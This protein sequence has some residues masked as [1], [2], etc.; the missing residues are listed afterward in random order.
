MRSMGEYGEAG[1]GAPK[2]PDSGLG[3]GQGQFLERY[4]GVHSA[5]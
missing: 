3:A 1:R 2:A 5:L 4:V